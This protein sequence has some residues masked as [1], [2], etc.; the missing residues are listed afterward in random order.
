MKDPQARDHKPLLGPGSRTQWLSKRKQALSPAITPENRNL[1]WIIRR[2]QKRTRVSGETQLLG[3]MGAQPRGAWTSKPQDL[4]WR[5]CVVLSPWIWG[6][7]LYTHGSH[8]SPQLGLKWTDIYQVKP[9]DG[10]LLVAPTTA[11]KVKEENLY[12]QVEE[13]RSWAKELGWV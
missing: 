8:S 5:M 2:V 9:Q 11:A 12:L 10:M 4:R 13:R 3:L 7:S 1:N 6:G